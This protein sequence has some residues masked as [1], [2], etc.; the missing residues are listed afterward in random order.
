[1]TTKI[2]FT[3][4]LL[5]IVGFCNAQI[6]IGSIEKKENKVP[7]VPVPEY[8]A[9]TNFINYDNFY[10]KVPREKMCEKSAFYNRY[11]DYVVYYPTF[12]DDY[13]QDECLLFRKD[14]KIVQLKWSDLA[15]QY[16]VI[17]SIEEPFEESEIFNE[18][19]K[20]NSNLNSTIRNGMLFKLEDKATNEIIYTVEFYQPS[21]VVT[22]YYTK[23]STGLP[24]FTFVAKKDFNGTTLPLGNNDFYVD[25]GSEWKAEITLLRKSDMDL[26]GD[27]NESDAQDLLFMV[28]AIHDTVKIITYLDSK[29][30]YETFWTLFDLKE[31]VEADKKANE[32]KAKQRLAELTTRYGESYAKD[33]RDGKL[34]IGMTKNMCQD[35]WGITLNR[36]SYSS[37]TNKID[38]WEYVGFGKLFFTDNKLSNI[39]RY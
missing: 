3:I 17:K 6:A 33:I 18:I 15:E 10:R 35:S 1:M 28:I 22:E 8:E 23:L 16:Y 9:S 21:F 5:L 24:K 2:R 32:N 37:A 4:A 39:I 26:M 19:I 27:Y 25:K 14:G 38:V 20:T 36:R 13:K 7:F 29:D 11:S 30:Y 31:N 34:R 12:T